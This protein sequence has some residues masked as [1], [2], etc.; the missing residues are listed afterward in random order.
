MNCELALESIISNENTSYKY[1]CGYDAR[2]AENINDI[3]HATAVYLGRRNTD[4]YG[5]FTIPS[6]RT[7]AS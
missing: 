3:F 7:P 1:S 4:E 2:N 5:R 6:G